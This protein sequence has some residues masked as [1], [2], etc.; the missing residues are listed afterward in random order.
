[1][2]DVASGV[3]VPA[4]AVE[5]SSDTNLILCSPALLPLCSS[6]SLMPLTIALVCGL[7]APCSG[8]DE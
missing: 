5:L 7:D 6:A 8:I 1:L 3:Q 4:W 2:A